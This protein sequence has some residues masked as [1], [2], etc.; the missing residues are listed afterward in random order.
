MVPSLQS[1]GIDRLSARDRLELAKDICDS[2][3][4]NE[5]S[6]AFRDYWREEIRR[7]VAEHDANPEDAIPWEQ[8]KAESLARYGK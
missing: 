4:P 6:A 5:P 1:L 7:R 8:I 2:I 3:P